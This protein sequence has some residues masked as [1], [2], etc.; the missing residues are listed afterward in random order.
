MADLRLENSSGQEIPYQIAPLSVSSPE[1]RL[2]QV[3]NESRQPLEYT[4][5]ISLGETGLLH[6]QLFL[7]ITSDKEYMADLYL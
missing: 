1:S 2:A 3:I 4:F 7:N 5:V 6:N